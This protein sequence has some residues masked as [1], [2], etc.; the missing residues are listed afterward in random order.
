MANYPLPPVVATKSSTFS[1]WNEVSGVKNT[2]S[3]LLISILGYGE[4]AARQQRNEYGG[5]T[6]EKENER[7]R[8]LSAWGRDQVTKLERRTEMTRKT[9]CNH[10]T[11]GSRITIVVLCKQVCKMVNTMADRINQGQGCYMAKSESVL[12]RSGQWLKPRNSISSDDTASRK[13]SN[14]EWKF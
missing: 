6:T 1:S 13:S 12:S 7:K 11:A 5:E 4:M 3:S 8:W 9:H 2:A 14:L 10:W